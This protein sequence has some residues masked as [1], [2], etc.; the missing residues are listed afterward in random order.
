MTPSLSK[1]AESPACTPVVDVTKSWVVENS[2]MD[3]VTAFLA[4][5]PTPSLTYQGSGQVT[6][7]ARV[8]TANVVEAAP[9][10]TPGSPTLVFA[11]AELA[12]GA[13]GIRVDAQVIPYGSVCA[14]SGGAASS[15]G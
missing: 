1:P 3:E 11:F 15:G 14:R 10:S 6:K 12:D 4:A 2:T 13:V 8:V 9:K 5:H 7:G